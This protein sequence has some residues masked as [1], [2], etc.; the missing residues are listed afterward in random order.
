MMLREKR[1]APY[2]RFLTILELEVWI[3]LAFAFLLTIFLL[4]I[5]ERYSPFSYRN[6]REKYRDEPDDRFC[7]LK[8]C[9]WFA[10]TS[11]TP[12]GGGDIPKNLSGKMVAAT[13]WLF[14][15]VIVAAYT[16]NLA[17]YETLDRLERNVESLEDLRRQFQIQYSVVAN[18]TAIWR[19]MTLDESVPESNR[20]GY[21]VWDYP[22]ENKYMTMYYAMEGYGFVRSVE[23]AV[24]FV[25][26]VNRA[27]EFAFIGE[28]ITIKYLILTDCNFKQVGK[29]FGKK[30]FAFALRKDSML[31]E[32]I[33]DAITHLAVRGRLN[34]LAKKWWEENPLR[35]NCPPEKYLNMGFD[36]DNLA[37]VFLL[38]LL[39]IL[40]AILIL[41]LEFCW[42]KS[43]S[44]KGFVASVAE[45]E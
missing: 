30:P 23:E 18:S 29:Q 39:G 9:F 24:K 36:L 45:S 16:A 44:S 7:S 17:A 27:Q 25:Q 38:I 10:F 2:L 20:S 34:V 35:M 8:E 32:R 40:L 22:L 14:G 19:N 6:N 15:F 41:C 12:Q 4:Y 28:A 11:I 13:W 42:K 21:V 1:Q 31:K 37:V 5:L 33:D 3:G 26:K 43:L